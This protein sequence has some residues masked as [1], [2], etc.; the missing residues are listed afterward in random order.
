[1]RTIKCNYFFNED[2]VHFNI[3]LVFFVIS[4]NKMYKIN[5]KPQF[6]YWK[7]DRLKR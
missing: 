4:T 6:V 2:I 5:M 7:K 3:N 1:M